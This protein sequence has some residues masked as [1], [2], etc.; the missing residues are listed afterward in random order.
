MTKN[1]KPS[2]SNRD[3]FDAYN[4]EIDRKVEENILDK[5]SQAIPAAANL[6]A[7]TERGYIFIPFLSDEQTQKFQELE[8]YVIHGKRSSSGKYSDRIDCS[9]IISDPGRA[10]ELTDFLNGVISKIAEN[11]EIDRSDPNKLGYIITSE[12]HKAEE[13]PYR[14]PMGW[15]AD[16]KL[17]ENNPDTVGINISIPILGAPTMFHESNNQFYDIMRG[18]GSMMNI[19]SVQK[20]DKPKPGQAALWKAAE[21]QHQN[22]ALHSV[23]KIENQKQKR[24]SLIIMTSIPKIKLKEKEAGSFCKK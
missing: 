19:D 9:D 24:L 23:P 11:L 4:K 15:H 21:Y 14:N 5:L 20:I 6:A 16:K 17:D 13:N 3:L 1:K 2:I 22:G 18:R 10:K 12:F 8:N 7:Q